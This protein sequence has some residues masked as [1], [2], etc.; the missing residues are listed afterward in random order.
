[1]FFFAFFWQEVQACTVD[2]GFTADSSNHP[3]NKSKNRYINILACTLLIFFNLFVFPPTCHL[4]VKTSPPL[5]WS[6]QSE[7]LQQS[8]QRREVWRLHQR[9]LRGREWLRFSR[10]GFVLQF[11]FRSSWSSFSGFPPR[12]TRDPER[13]SQPKGHSGLAE[14]TSGGWSGSRMLEWLSWSLTSKRKD[15]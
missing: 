14:R 11:H 9:Q 4:T 12:A 2:M 1:M 7:A 15:G 13:T 3:N 8:G 10:S 6:Q 5:R